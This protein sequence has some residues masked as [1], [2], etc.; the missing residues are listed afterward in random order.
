MFFFPF[1]IDLHLRGIPILTWLVML[2]CMMAFLHQQFTLHRYIEDLSRFC[3]H[4]VRAD[5]RAL[6]ASLGQGSE[7]VTCEAFLNAALD[8]REPPGAYVRGLLSELGVA[9]F[10]PRTRHLVDAAETADR[11]IPPHA[12]QQWMYLPQSP[13]LT[14]MFTSAFAHGGWQHLVMN[15]VFFLVFASAVEL[16]LGRV[17]FVLIFA[18]ACILP[19]L[20]YSAG[21]FGAD[22]SRPSLG[23][24]AVVMAYMAAIALLFPHRMVRV[25]YWFIFLIGVFR[26]PLLLLV[27]TY[28]GLD[29][30]GLRWLQASSNVGYLSHLVGAA[31]GCVAAILYLVFRAKQLRRF[32]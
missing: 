23:L 29:L 2:G 15:L 21:L 7:R 19:S 31:T 32:Y 22:N 28:V 13:S 12:T 25:F 8:S 9:P 30:Y 6:I 24:S 20:A 26:V 1:R 18:A 3:A 16:A 10:D 17:V 4:D 27:A 14:R 11:A 5:T